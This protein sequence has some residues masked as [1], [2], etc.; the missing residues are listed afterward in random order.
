MKTTT[1]MKPRLGAAP[2]IGEC[3]IAVINQL[4]PL[5]LQH[6]YQVRDIIN[7]APNIRIKH[8]KKSSF[9]GENDELRRVSSL[10]TGSGARNTQ[11]LPHLES[12][13]RR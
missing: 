11:E 3:S 4:V 13:L 2:I 12:S 1:P 9:I 10:Q 8:V 7:S 5:D 6:R